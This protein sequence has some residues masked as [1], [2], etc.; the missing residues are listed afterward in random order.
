MGVYVHDEQFIQWQ[1]GLTTCHTT[2]AAS[3]L[4]CFVVGQLLFFWVR[5]CGGT[6]QLVGAVRKQAFSNLV[7]FL[8]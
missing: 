3:A 1:F 8:R 4:V 7:T 5:S 6:S 2:T